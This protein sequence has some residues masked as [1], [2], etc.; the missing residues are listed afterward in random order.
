MIHAASVVGPAGPGGHQTVRTGGPPRRRRRVRPRRRDHRGVGRDRS[1]EARQARRARRRAAGARRADGQLADRPVLRRFRQRAGVPPADARH[2]RRHLPRSGPHQRPPL[3]PPAH[4]HRQL[5]RGGA[6]AVGG[7]RGAGPRRPGDHQRLADVGVARR[8]DPLPAAG[9]PVRRGVGRRVRVRRRLRGR[10]PRV[11]G[12]TPLPPAGTRD[13]RVPAGPGGE[14]RRRPRARTRR[15][16]G[17]TRRAGRGVRADA[18]RRPGVLL[19]RAQHGG[20]QHDPRLDG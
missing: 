18:P 13:L 6:R 3:H 17:A 20:A 11:G 1:R 7:E 12:R 5:R 14:P 16:L 15:A 9:H 4:H 10:L 2:C 19:P 8:A